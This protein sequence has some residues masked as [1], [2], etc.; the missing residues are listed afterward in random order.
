MPRVDIGNSFS[1][2]WLSAFVCDVGLFEFCRMPFGLKSASNTF[3]RA[4]SP[5]LQPVCPLS[6]SEHLTRPVRYL[7]VIKKSGLASS[8]KK[9]KFARYKVIFVGRVIVS[10]PKEVDPSKVSFL[11]DIQAPT[12]KKEVRKF[13]RVGRRE[14]KRTL[15]RPD[16]ACLSQE[17]TNGYTRHWGHRFQSLVAFLCWWDVK[18][19][20]ENK[21]VS[22]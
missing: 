11:A 18:Q 10:G 19:T 21:F 13:P 8:L 7:H 22:W 1:V 3:I 15:P 5:I 16:A 9:C 12:T 20:N 2:W 17:A 4:L 14:G 6:W